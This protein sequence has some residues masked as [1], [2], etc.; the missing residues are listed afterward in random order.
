MLLFR[1]SRKPRRDSRMAAGRRRR[2][3]LEQLEGRQM[4]VADLA[5]TKVDSPDP[6]VPGNI[7][8]YVITLTNQGNADQDATMVELEDVIPA[9]TTYDNFIETTTPNLFGFQI[10]PGAGPGHKRR[11]EIG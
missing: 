3:L 6:V 9:N 8:S 1:K 11:R 5:V 10:T 2:L 4:L 7:L